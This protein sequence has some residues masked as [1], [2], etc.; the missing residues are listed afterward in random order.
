M[1]HQRSHPCRPWAQT[2]LTLIEFMVAMALSLFCIF[3]MT[4]L[5]MA[6][7]NGFFGQGSVSA[8]HESQRLVLTTTTNT[9][10]LA[11]R[12]ARPLQDSLRSA[13]PA[14]TARS[15]SQAGQVV[16]GQGSNAG[17]DSTVSVRFQSMAGED[18]YTCLGTTHQGADST[19]FVNTYSLRAS[20]ELQCTVFDT[21]ANASR[22]PVVLARGIRSLKVWYGLDTTG[23]G[24]VDSYLPAASVSQS[25]WV[26]VRSIKLSVAFAD[27]VHAPAG[28]QAQGSTRELIQYIGLMNQVQY[29]GS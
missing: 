10:Q 17:V 8:I 18:L 20:G 6:F 28:G 4:G 9:L 14:D 29:A 5:Y 1:M 26:R 22:G 7:K 27:V 24:S 23:N 2:G 13:F 16:H 21:A 12:H 15:F 11:G 3:A 25:Q 19:V